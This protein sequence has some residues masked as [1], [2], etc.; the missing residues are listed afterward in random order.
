MEALERIVGELLR[1]DGYW[2]HN[3]YKVKLEKEDKRKLGTPTM[4]EPVLD[5]VAYKGNSN[6]VV[7]VECKNFLDSAGVQFRSFV[8]REHR[9]ASRYKLFNQQ[10]RR[11]VV[12][13]RLENQLLSAGFV[14]DEPEITLGLAASKFKSKE[15][16][17]LTTAH[18]NERGWILWDDTWLLDRLRKMAQRGYENNTVRV[19]ARVLFEPPTGFPGGSG[20]PRVR[21]TSNTLQCP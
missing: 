7:V 2:V 3:S 19:I 17:E 1:L 8:D 12:F 6:T 4:P 9:S 16:R 20:V 11:E 18:F 15:D 13:G 5:L 14:A 10:E 21:T